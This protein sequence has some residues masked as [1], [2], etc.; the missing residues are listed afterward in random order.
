M[1]YAVIGIPPVSAW[2]LI[3]QFWP[4]TSARRQKSAYACRGAYVEHR[5][6]PLWRRSGGADGNRP[7]VVA[8][9][10][11]GFGPAFDV[12]RRCWQLGEKF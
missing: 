1:G 2:A 5:V 12:A 7:R 10:G 8:K 4:W 6:S 11:L 9:T 3:Q